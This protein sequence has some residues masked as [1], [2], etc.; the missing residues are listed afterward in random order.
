M[1]QEE[2][3]RQVMEVMR[4]QT[5]QMEE[6]RRENELLRARQAMEGEQSGPRGDRAMVTQPDVPQGYRALGL[7]LS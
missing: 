4:I 2:V 3:R 6:L 1:V 7:Q 5:A